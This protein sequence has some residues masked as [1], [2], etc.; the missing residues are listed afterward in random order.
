MELTLEGVFCHLRHHLPI[1]K[2]SVLQQLQLSL[3]IIAQARGEVVND[4][5]CR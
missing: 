5:D 4:H 1:D 3:D 2:M